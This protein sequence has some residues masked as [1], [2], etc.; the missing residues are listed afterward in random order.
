[1]ALINIIVTRVGLAFDPVTHL[2]AQMVEYHDYA[3]PLDVRTRL[4]STAS[5]YWPQPETTIADSILQTIVPSDSVSINGGV[6]VAGT[7]P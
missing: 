3:N 2:Y 6:A 5:A 7:K 4:L 1:M